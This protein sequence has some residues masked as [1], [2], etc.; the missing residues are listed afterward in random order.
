VNAKTERDFNA[1]FTAMTDQHVGAALVASDPI[2]LSERV[3]MAQLAA[4]H[5]I[6]MVHFARE[7]VVAGG[8]A[9]YGSGIT[10][11]YHQA[12]IYCGRIL[13][14]AKVDDLP[15]QQPIKFDLIINLKTAKALSIPVPP[16]LIAIADE[17]IE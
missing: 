1:A 11:M 16:S 8:L 3:A 13:K 7:F 14:G 9:S 6:P 2:L 12:G 17:V 5:A 15:V 4:Q 10:G